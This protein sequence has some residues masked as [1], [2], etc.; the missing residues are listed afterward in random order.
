MTKRDGEGGNQLTMGGLMLRTK[1]L[2]P[3]VFDQVLRGRIICSESKILD[4]KV[5]DQVLRV[6]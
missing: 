6:C 3:K 1:D 5:F 2:D 4:P